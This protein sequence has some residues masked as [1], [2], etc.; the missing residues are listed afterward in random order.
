MVT[1]DDGV[2]IDRSMS[3]FFAG[4]YMSFQWVPYNYCTN[5]I[6][7]DDVTVTLFDSDALEKQ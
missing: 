2:M 5:L 1:L 7:L 4:V 6:E 3:R